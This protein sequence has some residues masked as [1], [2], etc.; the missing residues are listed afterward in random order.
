[1]SAHG[2]VSVCCGEA[3]LYRRLFFYIAYATTDLVV[4]V[5]A[6]F[7]VVWCCCVRFLLVGC[8]LS[9]CK[10]KRQDLVILSNDP[11][12]PDA[13]TKVSLLFADIVC[14]AVSSVNS[15]RVLRQISEGNDVQHFILAVAPRDMSPDTDKANV[16]NEWRR[17]GS[18]SEMNSAQK[19]WLVCIGRCD[20]I[21][22]RRLL[23]RLSARGGIRWDLDE[24]YKLSLKP[25]ESNECGDIFL[26]QAR[27]ASM[28][29]KVSVVHLNE[30]NA[31]QIRLELGFL[32]CFREHPHIQSVMG[33]FCT[34]E[35]AAK[36]LQW[37]FVSDT[38]FD[39]DLCQGW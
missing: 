34:N 17:R 19:V 26:G 6:V 22:V 37:S 23:W 31:A 35:A 28:P 9:I 21:Q 30:S 14:V 15:V 11:G 7:F 4:V 16:Y 38:T 24:L 1:M 36:Q 10:V 29:P 32:C 5:V 27:H 39:S 3:P 8:A 18:T 33:C 2:Q 12:D 20:G 25:V 13:T